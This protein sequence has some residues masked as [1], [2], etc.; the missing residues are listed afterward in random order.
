MGVALRLD[1]IYC[2]SKL[3][4]GCKDHLSFANVALLEIRLICD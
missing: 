1:I 3:L 2:C 4:T